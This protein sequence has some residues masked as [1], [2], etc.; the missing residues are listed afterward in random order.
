MSANSLG[1][2]EP[3]EG[4]HRQGQ[5]V[6]RRRRLPADPAGR[7]GRVLLLH[8]RLDIR[9]REAE[10]GHAV[11]IEA[12][13]H[14]EL[15]RA[16]GLGVAH[17]GNALELV[18]DVDLGVV[19]QIGR[20]VAGILRAER[21]DRE[22]VGL[23]LGDRDPLPHDLLRQLRLGQIDLVLDVNRREVEVPREVEVHLQV[24]RPVAGVR[25]LEVQQ[26]VESGELLLDRRRDRG[27][28]VLRGGPRIHRR[29][30]DRRRGDRGIPV[31]RQRVEREQRPAARSRSR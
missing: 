3:P 18:R 30:L 23:R 29:D 4:R 13:Q 2:G 10:L 8:R 6:P 27:G 20:V 19:V 7:I 15:E 1:I 9:H 16:D 12:Q 22:D 31:D 14:R 25:R 24:H 5:L 21:D 17:P 26:A 11:G 28:D